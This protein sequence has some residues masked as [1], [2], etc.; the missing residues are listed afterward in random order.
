MGSRLLGA[1]ERLATQNPSSPSLLH[2]YTKEGVS[3]QTLEGR[4]TSEHPCTPLLSWGPWTQSPGPEQGRFP[5]LLV[6]GWELRILT[7]A[8]TPGPGGLPPSPAL[9]SHPVLPHSPHRPPRPSQ[10]RT[11]L[12]SLISP[13]MSVPP[14][15]PTNPR[16][17]RCRSSLLQEALCKGSSPIWISSPPLNMVS[18][19]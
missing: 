4:L 17:A 6:S 5:A 18:G 3:N 15:R 7:S 12:T 16:A 8:R 9:A 19:P 2:A 13:G 14:S 1:P 11:E 10:L